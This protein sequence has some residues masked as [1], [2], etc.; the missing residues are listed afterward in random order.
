MAAPTRQQLDMLSSVAAVA[1]QAATALDNIH[2]IL[3]QVAVS[4]S[5]AGIPTADYT[6]TNQQGAPVA[7]LFANFDPTL[8]ANFVKAANAV[9][10]AVDANNAEIA[11]AFQAMSEFAA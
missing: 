7:G 11:K 6:A 10:A 2:T 1:K 3:R 4:P 8:Y 9:A 5:V